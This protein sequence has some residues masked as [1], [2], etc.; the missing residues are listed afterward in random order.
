MEAQY[1]LQYAH[2]LALNLL[3]Y[4]RRARFN[5]PF[6]LVSVVLNSTHAVIELL[7]R[8]LITHNDLQNWA[9]PTE[10]PLIL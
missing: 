4:T 8:S 7:H 10:K 3:Y 1:D 2:H 6:T 5:H 9:F